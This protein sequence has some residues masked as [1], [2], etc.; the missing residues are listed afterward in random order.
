MKTSS[1]V[2]VWLMSLSAICG[3]FI[4][5]IAPDKTVPAL[6]LLG[7]TIFN[8]LFLAITE[9]SNIFRALKMRSAIHGTNS[10][11]LIA[12][13]L[14][15]L[16]FINLIGYR[17]KQQYD[18]T[19]SGFYTLS[20]QTQKIIGSLSREVKMTAFFQADSPEK[21]LFQDRMQSLLESSK[22]I[23]LSSI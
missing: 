7:L 12:A 15:I 3:L 4:Y 8:A 13:V 1:K 18:F 23:N 20:P 11:I 2:A 22:Q 9:R 19:K 17:H 5:V 16:I 6:V 14:G 10:I 21:S